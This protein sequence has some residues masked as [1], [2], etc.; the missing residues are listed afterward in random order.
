MEEFE[1]KESEADVRRIF[2]SFD[3]D[4]GGT[5]DLRELKRLI[6]DLGLPLSKVKILMP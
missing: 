5:V 6:K 4:C 3:D 2:D 1:Q